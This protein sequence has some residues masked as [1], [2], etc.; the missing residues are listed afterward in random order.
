MRPPYICP[1]SVDLFLNIMTVR[2]KMFNCVYLLNVTDFT[3][4]INLL[5]LWKLYVEFTVKC[6]C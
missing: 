6:L 1:G 3:C 4:F 2:E 5:I